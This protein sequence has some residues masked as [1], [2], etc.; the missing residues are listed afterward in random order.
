[1]VNFLVMDEDSNLSITINIVNLSHRFL[2]ENLGVPF[3][4]FLDFP[5]C[6]W[7]PI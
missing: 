1:M 4:P 3:T 2:F 5:S 6:A 7:A